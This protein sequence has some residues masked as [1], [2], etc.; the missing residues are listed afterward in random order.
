MTLSHFLETLSAEQSPVLV[1]FYA[2]WCEPCKLLDKYLND[3]VPLIHGKAVIQKVDIDNSPE[4]KNEFNIMSVPTLIIFKGGEVKWR[5]PGFMLTHEMA[6]KVLS[7]C[8]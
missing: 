3:I 7:F 6:E 5:M 2:E 8:D 1:D 4:L